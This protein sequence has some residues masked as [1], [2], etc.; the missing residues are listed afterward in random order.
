[1]K[2]SLFSRNEIEESLGSREILEAIE[3]TF[4]DLALGKTT[5]PPKLTLD[6]GA[7]SSY[8]PY[9][10]FINA[11]PAYV[12][13]LDMAGLKWAGAIPERAKLGHSSITGMLMLL[14]PCS[15]NFLAV[16]DGLAITELRFAAQDAVAL[17][18]LT[19]R[20]EIDVGFLGGGEQVLL[21]LRF[22]K[23]FFSVRNVYVDAAYDIKKEACDSLI[24]GKITFSTPVPELVSNSD[25]IFGIGK[26]K[27]PVIKKDDLRKGAVV[28]PLGSYNRWCH[29]DVLLEGSE[30]LVDHK[31]QCL[32]KGEL[33]F[34]VKE[35]KLDASSISGTIGEL[36]SKE[37]Q[38]APDKTKICI[39]LGIGALDI[40]LGGICYLK[41]K[42]ACGEFDFQNY[43]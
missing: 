40:A 38:P 43:V 21:H 6:L 41:M 31:E 28:F 15:G 18:H 1:M 25:A 19:D 12:G 4:L 16:M 35:G 2:T 23:E 33:S 30:I 7:L 22:L 36:I 39:P 24:S 8:P 20:E 11:M 32:E 34:L 10:G 42:A 27:N 14:D 13:W 26:S 9:G 3:K 17:K 29:D 5:N 37:I